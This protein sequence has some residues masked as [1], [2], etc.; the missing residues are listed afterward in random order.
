MCG[1]VESTSAK[2]LQANGWRSS[3]EG[4]AFSINRKG[5]S[6]QASEIMLHSISFA[7]KSKEEKKTSQTTQF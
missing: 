4:G 6:F 5:R 3:C 2:L 7:T 1:V